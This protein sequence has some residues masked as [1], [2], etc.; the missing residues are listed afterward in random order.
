MAP[1]WWMEA[2][3]TSCQGTLIPPS[4]GQNIITFIKHQH[5]EMHCWNGKF[6]K[7]LSSL[8]DDL[9]S[10]QK[11]APFVRKVGSLFNAGPQNSM[12]KVIK[13]EVIHFKASL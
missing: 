6:F 13:T 7:C 3:S 1:G 9:I 11:V 10:L 8:V 5:T 2:A 12:F 4:F